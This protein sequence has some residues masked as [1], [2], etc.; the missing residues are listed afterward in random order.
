MFVVPALRS[1][2]QLARNVAN[3]SSLLSRSTKV[4]STS[5]EREGYL[6]STFG[7]SNPAHRIATLTLEDG[8]VLEGASFGAETPVAGEVVFNTG[9][10]GLF[11]V[12]SLFV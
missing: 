8:T 7:G 3:K 12:H 9:M 1:K 2:H 10:M 6:G 5:V 4:F 11:I